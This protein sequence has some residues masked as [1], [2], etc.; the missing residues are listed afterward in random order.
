MLTSYILV[1]L[2]FIPFYLLGAFPTGLLIAKF[3]GIDISK[4]GSGNVGATNIARTLGKKAG[5]LTLLIDCSKGAL[6]VI[7]A[8]VLF[9]DSNLSAIT[10]MLAVMGHCISIP[11]KLRGGKGVATSLGVITALSPALGGAVLCI[12]LGVFAAFR[13][14]S[15]ASIVAALS[16]PALALVFYPDVLWHSWIAFIAFLVIYKHK[17]NLERVIEGREPRFTFSSTKNAK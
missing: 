16:A 17:D 10:G 12:F 7:I 8:D 14:V 9:H 11:G 6:A 5:F 1:F 3:H 15:V 13:M 2:A 4:H